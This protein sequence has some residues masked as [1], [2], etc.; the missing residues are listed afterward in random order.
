VH[1]HYFFAT[2]WIF[3]LGT[4]SV[5]ENQYVSYHNEVIMDGLTTVYTIIVHQ[6]AEY[7]KK[8]IYSDTRCCI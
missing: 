3:L 2:I 7:V 1:I 8:H 5:V 4:K 6:S